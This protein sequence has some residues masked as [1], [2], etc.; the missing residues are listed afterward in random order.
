MGETH[1]ADRRLAAE[2]AWWKRLLDVQRPYRAHLRRLDLGLV[3]E[4]GCGIG[5]NLD[6]LRGRSVGVDRDVRS[7]EIARGRGLPA[8]TPEE[9]RASAWGQEGR[10][11][12]LLFSHVLEH[13]TSAQAG[14]LIR[15]YLP[16]LRPG[17]R[18]VVFTPQEAGFRSDPTHVEFMDFDSVGGIA[19]AAGLEVESRY[20]FPFP[21]LAGSIF[22]YNEFVT[23]ARNR[24]S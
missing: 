7:V 2:S 13:M 21:R 22:K 24:I 3:L 10:F 11:D 12:S 14:E 9:L 5:R 18:V 15:A 19:R 1:Y 23:V 6:H 8:F 4:I 20:S 16:F 17:G